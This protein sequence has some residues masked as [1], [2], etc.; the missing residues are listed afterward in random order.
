LKQADLALA[1]K[2]EKRMMRK[3]ATAEKAREETEIN[4]LNTG[5][6]GRAQVERVAGLRTRIEEL[7][8]QLSGRLPVGP[9]WN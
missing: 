5:P 3:V 7:E 8:G 1:E 4:L 2:M 6:I 9:P